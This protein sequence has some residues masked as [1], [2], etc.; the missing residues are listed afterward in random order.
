MEFATRAA[1]G[2]G[3]SESV[4]PDPAAHRHTTPYGTVLRVSLQGH[5]AI[6]PST[7]VSRLNQPRPAR[8]TLCCAW[9]LHHHEKFRHEAV[10]ASFQASASSGPAV[11]RQA[12]SRVLHRAI[13]NGR[14]A[15][16]P[17]NSACSV[18]YSSASTYPVG[19]S[20]LLSI[21]YLMHA[22]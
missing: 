11:G 6:Q 22:L 7:S 15:T 20:P 14:Q 1:M 2:S 19:L 18:Q 3:L 8:S 12:L 17:S 13:T 4:R 10:L 5:N 16:N 9:S 21:S